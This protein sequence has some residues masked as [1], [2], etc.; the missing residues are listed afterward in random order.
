MN[1][2][3]IALSGDVWSSAHSWS[4]GTVPSF[5]D[6]VIFA[7]GFSNY[8]CTVDVDA[9]V[10]DLV[11]S[12]TYGGA[13]SWA[14][15]TLTASGNITL[16]GSGS[17]NLGNG[18]T[19]N[20]A[21]GTFHVGT[22]VGAVTA[23]SFVLT[24]NTATAGVIDI[25]KG[26]VFCK[27]FVIS[28]AAAV[29]NSGAAFP[30]TIRGNVTPIIIG[31]GAT[32]ISTQ[33]I[34]I[35]P[36]AAVTLW[37]IGAGAT[38]TVTILVVY[39]QG[40]FNGTITVPAAAISATRVDFQSTGAADLLYNVTGVLNFGAGE[41]R[42]INNAATSKITFITNDY[43]FSCGVVLVGSNAAGGLAT[44]NFGSSV[45]ACSAFDGLTYN[46]ATTTLNMQTSTW[47]CSGSWTFGS[48][49]TID[50]GTSVINCVGTANRDLT[51]NNKPV[52]D[53][54]INTLSGTVTTFI[55][56]PLISGDFTVT[57]GSTD[58]SNLS[59]SGYGD[60]LF[61]GNGQHVIGSGI[62]LV[63]EGTIEFGNTLGNITSAG[64]VVNFN[65]NGN[66]YVY[67]NDITINR[68]ILA[69]GCSYKIRSE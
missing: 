67:D 30:T 4:L 1:N 63:N 61:N 14:S 20:G 49:H 42:I 17:L 60:I 58:L 22:G 35:Q 51:F 13:L 34:Y 23:T 31:A 11:T 53:L 32:F 2:N 43:N 16:D 19:C 54:N 3:W 40:N 24:M 37:D 50:P 48:N 69:S 38:V 36:T 8:A 12:G 55:D 6:N 65:N 59:Y 29:T 7:S 28:P 33:A 21:S 56:E 52:Y 39:N 18:V 10:N 15:H 5:S 25:D 57:E 45:I 66:F 68:M 46:N 64:C 62:T 27:Q 44:Y 41:F 47:T 26:S 9:E